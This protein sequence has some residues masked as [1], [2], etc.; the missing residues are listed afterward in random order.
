MRSRAEG[1]STLSKA[2]PSTSTR[3]PTRAS[4]MNADEAS[5]EEVE[6]LEGEAGALRDA[7]ERV[8]GHVARDAGDLGHELVHVAQQRAAAREDHP[9]VD[10]VGGELRRRLLENSLHRADDL[11]EDRIHRLGDLVAADRDGAG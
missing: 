11:L 8:L 9:L 3:A 10:D 2:I 7:V 1:R 6:V 4:L 5:L